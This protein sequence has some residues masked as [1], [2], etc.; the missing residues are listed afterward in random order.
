METTLDN[1][2]TATID[3]T[4]ST[5]LSE[6]ELRDVLV[7]TLDALADI[8][9]VGE[10]GTTVAFTQTLGRGNF[11]RL[12]AAGEQVG[13]V[14][15]D[16]GEEPRD[17]ES[18]G[19]GLRVVVLPDASAGLEV[20]LGQTLL[21]LLLH[22]LCGNAGL[23]ELG[24]EVVGVIRRLLGLLLFLQRGGVELAVGCGGLVAF[25]ALGI[26]ALL[27]LLLFGEALEHLSDLVDLVLCMWQWSVSGPGVQMC[28][29]R[30]GRGELHTGGLL[31]SWCI[32]DLA[33]GIHNDRAFVE[34]DRFALLLLNC[35]LGERH[36]V[37]GG[38]KKIL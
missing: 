32:L 38:I 30:M 2:T 25:A 9:D 36:K 19:D 13:V 23:G 3:G 34:C 18:I 7:G 14:A 20:A 35:L 26:L 15:L 5:Q 17:E 1:Q 11:V 4:A 12:G 22:I 31:G 27:A 10:N 33:V 21:T 37:S 29:D 6:Q 24:L 28:G 8:G 16:E